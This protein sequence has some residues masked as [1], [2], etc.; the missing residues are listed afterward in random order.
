MTHVFRKWP[1]N[2]SL[3]RREEIAPQA[4]RKDDGRAAARRG[5][6]QVQ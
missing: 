5:P 4:M 3:P 1:V 6:Q 2:P